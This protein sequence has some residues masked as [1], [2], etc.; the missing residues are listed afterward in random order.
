M[1]CRKCGAEIPENKIY[2]ETCGTPIQM[3]PD[4]NPVEDI[5][6]GE[7]RP[8]VSSSD[9]EAGEVAS[10]P[11]YRRKR[12]IGLG[13]LAVLCGVLIYHG[14]YRMIMGPSREAEAEAILL[15]EKP[16]LSLPSGT[17]SY[18]PSLTI[19]HPQREEGLIFYTTDGSTPN[20]YSQV[21][22]GPIVIGEGKTVVRAI[23][24][25]S[26]GMQ[27]E[28]ADGTYQVV[29]EFP[30]EPEFSVDSGEYSAPFHVT[31]SAEPDCTI[32]YTM[33]GSDPDHL[34]SVYRGPVYIPSGFTVLRAVS[35]NEEGDMS[36]IMEA[37]Y[38]VEEN[39]VPADA[40]AEGM[41]GTAAEN[42]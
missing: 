15:L 5:R 30:D 33:D 20:E 32:H 9:E 21:F 8:P 40:A 1:K 28:E 12:Y 7:E 16:E 11:F 19:S 24:I 29:F 14:G 10:I 4:Y 35:M 37:I 31:I 34:S 17:Y 26:D 18:M 42:P 38:N 6:I 22:N 13:I 2:C 41:P 23:F 25:R 3:V 39:T 27:S 36:G